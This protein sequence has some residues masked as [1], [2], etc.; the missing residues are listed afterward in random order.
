MIS[1]TAP[2]SLAALYIFSRR[3]AAGAFDFS[4][5]RQCYWRTLSWWMLGQTFG[6]MVNMSQ[7]R[8]ERP[9]LGEH[10][11]QQRVIQNESAHSVLR[12]M[13]FHLNTRQMSVWEHD[14]R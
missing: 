6:Q 14:P 4:M 12:S 11:L 10:H 9:S 5:L 13:K 8:Q 1:N 2:Y 7:I 3:G